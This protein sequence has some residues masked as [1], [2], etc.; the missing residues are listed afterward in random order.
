MCNNLDMP[1]K[2]TLGFYARCALCQKEIKPDWCRLG[3]PNGV[4]ICMQCEP[5]LRA[6]SHQERAEKF[7][8]TGGTGA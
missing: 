1:D 4:Q 7:K 6:M 2:K 3:G 5:K 8:Y